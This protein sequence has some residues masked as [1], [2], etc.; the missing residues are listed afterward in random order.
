M[1]IDLHE[2]QKATEQKYSRKNIKTLVA[3]EIFDSSEM[4]V[5]VAK[6]VDLLNDYL[7]K[8]YSYE[9]KN[10]RIAQFDRDSE[11]T[12]KSIFTSLFLVNGTQDLTSVVGTIVNELGM[13]SIIDGV[14][15]AAEILAVLCNVDL[16]D[17]Y[18]D[19]KYDSLKLK[20][21]YELSPQLMK[22]ISETHYLPPT[23]VKPDVVTSNYD[24][25]S[26]SNKG[27]MILG[28]AN[29][30]DRDICL[31]SLNTFNSVP[32][33]LNV[34]LL[35][36]FSEQKPEEFT[37]ED[38]KKQWHSFVKQSYRIYKDLIQVGNEFYLYNKPDKRG[39]TYSQG[40]HVNVQGNKFRK[41]II[42]FAEQEVVTV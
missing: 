14:K 19:S 22:Y 11:R 6:G 24:Y 26:Y 20:M 35:T 3:K 34:A 21:N 4:T 12:V 42:E 39:R 17:I 10:V 36:Q 32:L 1:T 5:M 13:S 15:T 18:K 29:Y 41:A 37:N 40:Y 30:H 23:V 16:Y 2:Y 38:H 9:T 33:T 8:T 27:N 7:G 28:K 25:D 31:D